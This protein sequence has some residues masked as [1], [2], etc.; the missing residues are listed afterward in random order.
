MITHKIVTACGS[1]L[2]TGPALYPAPDYI[3]EL[4]ECYYIG[5]CKNYDCSE[6][7]EVIRNAQVNS[8]ARPKLKEF[9]AQ[10]V[11]K[12]IRVGL[13]TKLLS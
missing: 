7:L 10:K 9:D 6:C 13:D 4:R 8:N 5:V 11:L 2:E 12:A 1:N 3:D